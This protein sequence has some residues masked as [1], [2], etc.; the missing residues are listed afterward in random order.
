[1]NRTLLGWLPY[2]RNELGARDCSEAT[3]GNQAKAIARLVRHVGDVPP[4]SVTSRALEE[5]RDEMSATLKPS[6]V[7]RYLLTVGTFFNWLAAEGVLAAA[8]TVSVSL[9]VERDAGAPP[10][11]DRTVLRRLAAGAGTVTRGRS[12]FEATR[13]VAML[14]LLIDSGLRASE[15]A[16]L[17][18]DNLDLPARQAY[19]HDAVAKGRSARTVTFGFETAKLANRYLIAR[20]GHRYAFLPQAFLG[21][22]GPATYT[23]VRDLVRK[24]GMREGVIGARPHLF[25]HTWAHDLKREGVSDE[26]LMSLAGW[27]TPAMLARYGR[28]E[29]TARAV[30]AYQRVGSPVDRARVGSKSQTT[31]RRA[32]G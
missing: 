3:V 30:E 23:V 9:L 8:P 25:R 17:L 4:A 5:W 16:G 11:L 29:K 28:A 13:D 6:T 20:E 26:V 10:V 22:Q 18:L 15:L 12:R 24:A 14:S 31:K 1:M 27:R 21:R 19:V 7:N 2:W 32:A